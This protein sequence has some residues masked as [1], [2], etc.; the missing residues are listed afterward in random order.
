[1]S[2]RLVT[3]G[4]T[5]RER[6]AAAVADPVLQD[7]LANLTRRLRTATDLARTRPDLRDAAARIRRETLTDL[8]TWI[9]RLTEALETT[10]ARVHHAADAAAAVEIVVGIARSAGARRVTKSKSMATEEIGLAD[11][12]AAAGI[13]PVETD[14][15]EYA[16]Q[17]AGERPSHI[18]TPVIHKTVAGVA[19]TFRTRTGERVPSDPAG[20]TGWVRDRLRPRFTDAPVSITGANFAVAETGT[21][22]LVTNEGNADLGTA[23]APV[24][25]AV[26]PVEKVV[27]RFAD[28]A[29]LL[30]LLTGAATGQHLTAYVTLLHG[31][32][33]A[34]ER[35]GPQALHVVLLDNGRRR[36]L[37]TR[38][39]EMLAC[40]RCGACLNVCPVF[41]RVSGHAYDAT[42]TG[43][44]G[45][46]LTPLLS[47]GAEGA[48]L[49]WASSLCG[50][51]SEAC[52]V[53][54]PLADLLVHLRAD[55]RGGDPVRPRRRWRARTGLAGAWATVWSRPRGYRAS[56]RLAAPALRLL[57]RLPGGP[58][59]GRDLPAVSGST[60]GARWRA[61]AEGR[62]RW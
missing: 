16:V 59:A 20:I 56:L 49:P 24:Q 9:A 45:A 23:C 6:T 47:R 10:G 36:L 54:I 51:C 57:R 58:G 43:P 39:A 60:F 18:I 1:M 46:V 4:R 34:A 8:D 61:R 28:L 44:M 11:A 31:P 41:R 26:V 13:E 62:A 30:P 38:Y 32:R 27:P 21:L 14:L 33:R 3:P 48:E 52:P 7:A 25:V 22:V 55:L 17:V 42:Y 50:A 29:V 40:I 37:G 2:G 5:V 35:D 19:A 15:G 12:L 53:S